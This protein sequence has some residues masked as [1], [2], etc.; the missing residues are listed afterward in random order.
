[1]TTT[2][3]NP[4][5]DT[6]APALPVTGLAAGF[7]TVARLPPQSSETDVAARARALRV[8]LYGMGR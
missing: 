4:A 3:P 8:G 5:R 7:H 6:R 1:M 2:A